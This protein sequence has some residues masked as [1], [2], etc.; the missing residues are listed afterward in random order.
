MGNPNNRIDYHEP[1]N[2]IFAQ[3][4]EVYSNEKN[5]ENKFSRLYIYNNENITFIL[6]LFSKSFF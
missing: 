3:L 1:M 4:K 6:A 5:R 2:H